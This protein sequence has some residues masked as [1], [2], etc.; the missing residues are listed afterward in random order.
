MIYALEKSGRDDELYR[1]RLDGFRH[2]GDSFTSWSKRVCSVGVVP[3]QEDG[4]S[5]AVYACA[6]I[7][8]ISAGAQ[9]QG[10]DLMQLFQW[11]DMENMREVC[12]TVAWY[13][14]LCPSL[15]M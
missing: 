1:K 15:C 7:D 14:L 12:D 9:G 5:C 3:R 2:L 10:G 8:A 11:K 4:A 13:L 6:Y